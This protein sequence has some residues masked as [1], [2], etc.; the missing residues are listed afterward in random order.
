MKMAYSNATRKRKVI[1][2][3]Q[4]MDKECENQI[5]QLKRNHQDLSEPSTSYDQFDDVREPEIRKSKPKINQD[6]SEPSTSFTSCDISNNA[7]EADQCDSSDTEF[8][9]DEPSMQ[10]SSIEPTNLNA[11]SLKIGSEEHTK[12]VGLIRLTENSHDDFKRD[13]CNWAIT[14]NITHSSLNNL[15]CLMNSYGLNIPSD[16][17][18]LLKTPRNNIKSDPLGSGDFYY[19]GITKVIKEK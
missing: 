13:L 17:R 9:I 10:I 15:L 16:A 14:E 19:F 3:L 18:S 8:E 5:S 4:K 11:V 12:T 6:I 2:F 7:F 1:S